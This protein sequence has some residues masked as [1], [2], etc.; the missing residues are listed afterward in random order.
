MSEALEL[1]PIDPGDPDIRKLAMIELAWT[2][3]IPWT[4]IATSLGVR[5]K[6]AAK[7]IRNDLERRIRLKQH[8]PVTP[9]EGAESVH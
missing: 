8:A 6:R 7:R 5:D 4:A 9:E 1:R 2:R 3:G